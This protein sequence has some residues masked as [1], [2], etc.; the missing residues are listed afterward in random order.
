MSGY[1]DPRNHAGQLQMD[2]K[3]RQQD[4]AEGW[5]QKV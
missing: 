3:Q 1:Q 4:W 5:E 2:E